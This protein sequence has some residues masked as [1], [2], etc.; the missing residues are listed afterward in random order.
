[1]T[2]FIVFKNLSEELSNLLLGNCSLIENQ[3]YWA[4]PY[5]QYVFFD[6][7]VQ[8]ELKKFEHHRVH[9]S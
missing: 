6:T 1:M 8:D 7:K 2:I 4:I 5:D 9:T 3:G